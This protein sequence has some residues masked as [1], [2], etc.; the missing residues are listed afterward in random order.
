MPPPELI[1]AGTWVELHQIVLAPGERAPNVPEET[2]RVPM[3]LRVR[4]ALLADALVGQQATITT[5]TG[6]RH[7][8]VLVDVNP[9]YDHGYGRPVPELAPIRS[10]LRALLEREATS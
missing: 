10:E 1:P 2:Q 8:G 5:V 9:A 4:G 7:H 6:R 3:E